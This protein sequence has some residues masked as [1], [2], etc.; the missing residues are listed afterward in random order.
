[1]ECV[2]IRHSLWVSI[3]F[4]IF[5]F[6][7]AWQAKA[8]PLTGVTAASGSLFAGY[9]IFSNGQAS[10]WAMDPYGSGNLVTSPAPITDSSGNILAGFTD[11]EG[12]LFL[13]GNC[14]N[15]LEVTV[16]WDP[17]K[18]VY[19]PTGIAKPVPGLSNVKQISSFGG[20]YYI[21]TCDNR[22]YLYNG[23]YA[24]ETPNF[25]P[26]GV[27][28]LT[29]ISGD[30][31]D[32]SLLAKYLLGLSR[33][34]S[35]FVRGEYWNMGQ[36]GSG[37][38]NTTWTP[39][40]FPSAIGSTG[41]TQV[42]ASTQVSAFVKNGLVYYVVNAAGNKVITVPGLTGVMSIVLYYEPYYSAPGTILIA[43]KS[44]GTV[45]MYTVGT[46]GAAPTNPWVNRNRGLGPKLFSGQSGRC[47]R[48][49]LFCWSEWGSVRAGAGDQPGSG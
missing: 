20:G 14:G 3:G 32:N 17:I 39:V 38:N 49:D 37:Y 15:A 29:S 6:S 21:L 19:G 27:A 46:G 24:T 34:G 12:D 31:S 4:I 40:N 10:G 41:F 16:M 9:A 22:G 35:V 45:W 36:L 2:N 1:M 7:I 26:S 23:T 43:R 47:R 18:G 13:Q 5:I 28:A 25:L 48:C 44:D 11:V 8:V 42:L 30:Y 33:N